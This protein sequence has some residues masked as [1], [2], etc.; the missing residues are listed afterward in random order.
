MCAAAC[1]EG[2]YCPLLPHIREHAAYKVDAD[3]GAGFPDVC[4]SESRGLPFD[5]SPDR[6]SL[7]TPRTTQLANLALEFLVGSNQYIQKEVD[8]GPWVMCAFVPTHGTLLKHFVIPFL[9][10][11]DNALKADVAPC[12]HATMISCKQEKQSRY[13]TVAIA[14]GVYAQEVEIQCRCKNQ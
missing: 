1:A 8:G 2:F 4:H 9:I 10:L 12:F 7:C 6:C 13:P 11:L 3:S 5:G 14:E